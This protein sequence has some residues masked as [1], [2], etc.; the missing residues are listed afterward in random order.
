MEEPE[1]DTTKLSA[2]PTHPQ[3]LSDA[4]IQIAGTLAD[5]IL[6]MPIQTIKAEATQEAI[7][8]HSGVML[9]ALTEVRDTRDQSRALGSILEHIEY[10][11]RRSFQEPCP[12]ILDLVN[13]A[14]QR[15]V[16]LM[17]GA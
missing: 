9:M 11:A 1:L 16:W 17:E 10:L 2:V 14:Q 5:L 12:E 13:Q 4:E 3:R 8:A 6:K 7:A 15:V